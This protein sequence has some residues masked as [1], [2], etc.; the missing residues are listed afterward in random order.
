MGQIC[1]VIIQHIATPPIYGQGTL[2]ILSHT[3]YASMDNV[4]LE[5][6]YIVKALRF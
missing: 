6:L 4:F 5:L 1:N 3:R 2:H